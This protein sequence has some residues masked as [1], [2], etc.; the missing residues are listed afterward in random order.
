MRG[1]NREGHATHK[2]NVDIQ[3]GDFEW[4]QKKKIKRCNF[5]GLKKKKKK[6]KVWTK[7][8]ELRLPKMSAVSSGK[9]VYANFESLD[10]S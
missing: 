3:R 6:K 2:R 1:K 7:L 10:L 4:L 8:T 5:K 9:V